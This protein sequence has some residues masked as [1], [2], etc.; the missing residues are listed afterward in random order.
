MPFFQYQPF[1]EDMNSY[2]EPTLHAM[3]AQARN[4]N[5]KL[6]NKA[7]MV[8]DIDPVS[9][10]AP[11]KGMPTLGH[12]Y[13]D[14]VKD[15]LKLLS[16]TDELTLTADGRTA[17]MIMKNNW[18]CLNQTLDLINA[19]SD[20]FEYKQSARL[21]IAMSWELERWSLRIHRALKSSKINIQKA[22]ELRDKGENLKFAC[23]GIFGS[24]LDYPYFH[25]LVYE[26]VNSLVESAEQ[27]GN[28]L[29]MYCEQVI[30]HGVKIL[31]NVF[32]NHNTSQGLYFQKMMQYYI[33]VT[34]LSVIHT[35]VDLASLPLCHRVLLYGQMTMKRIIVSKTYVM[36]NAENTP[37]SLMPSKSEILFLN[38]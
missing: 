21:Y 12:C 3:L 33:L 22:L 37:N 31:G 1:K 20:D 23:C 29:G 25:K 11:L 8:W 10:L 32:K 38:H 36:V 28:G 2:Y 6:L 34:F 19:K 35:V 26:I 5:G 4:K 7:R 30:E 15:K 24:D 13:Y 17:C 16:Q 9:M 14:Q 27:N 18:K